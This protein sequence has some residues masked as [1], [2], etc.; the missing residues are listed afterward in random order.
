M[1]KQMDLEEERPR[2]TWTNA[3]VYVLA[4]VCLLSGLLL[5]YLFRGSSPAQPAP[6]T[7]AAA[8]TP[9]GTPDMPSADALSAMA[10]P[11]LAKLKSDPS[12]ADALIQLGNLYYDHQAFEKAIQ[13]YAQALEVRPN[14]VNVRSDMATAYWYL[15]KPESAVKEYEK[16]L[17]IDPKHANTL[18]NLGVV[19]W[20]GL[21]DPKGAIALWKKLL[22]L[23]PDYPDRQKVEVLIKH[24]Q[25]GKGFPQ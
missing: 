24:A 1:R 2:P 17:Q 4:L 20:Q 23:N 22:E 21:K 18:F 15:G 14:D 3:Q 13:Y 8:G 19:K 9:A 16:A 5:G 10:A 25:S 11:Q 6:S 7:V 12:D